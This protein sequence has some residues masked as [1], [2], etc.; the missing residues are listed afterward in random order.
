MSPTDIGNDC[1]GLFPFSALCPIPLHKC[2]ACVNHPKVPDSPDCSHVA[3]ST[4]IR[5]KGLT[6]CWRGILGNTMGGGM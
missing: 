6:E 4:N 1:A 2:V 3:D 5:V